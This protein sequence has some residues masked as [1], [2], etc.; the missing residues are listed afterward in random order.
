MYLGSMLLTVVLYSG[1]TRSGVYLAL[2][3]IL[4]EE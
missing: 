4:V 3:H 2:Y 1:D